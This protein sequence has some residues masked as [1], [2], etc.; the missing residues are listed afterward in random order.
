MHNAVL[1]FLANRADTVEHFA[2]GLKDAG[3]VG[4]RLLAAYPALAGVTNVE[5]ESLNENFLTI[6]SKEHSALTAL[7]LAL[8]GAYAKRTNVGGPNNV[9]THYT[10]KQTLLVE[11]L[12]DDTQTLD[13]TVTLKLEGLTANCKL[14]TYEEDVPATRV[15]RYRVNCTGDT[16]PPTAAPEESEDDV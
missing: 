8:G 9:T 13:L 5:V 10:R 7:M 1:T 4:R 3:R 16:P 6:T 2:A 12:P 14:E 11:S 15:T